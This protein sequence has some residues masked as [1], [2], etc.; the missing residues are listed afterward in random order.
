MNE[1]YKYPRTVYFRTI[2]Q[3]CDKKLG[4]KE[5]MKVTNVRMKRIGQWDN[6]K[7]VFFLIVGGH[8][9]IYATNMDNGI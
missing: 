7:I 9:N 5:N 4:N 3:L 8:T 1:K 6:H 2:I